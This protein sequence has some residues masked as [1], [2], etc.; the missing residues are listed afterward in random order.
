MIQ[1]SINLKYKPSSEPPAMIVIEPNPHKFTVL[2]VSGW[3]RSSR[4]PDL[5]GLNGMQERRDV[6]VW[7][8]GT[9]AGRQGQRDNKRGEG[10][11]ERKR[12][13]KEEK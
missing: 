11:K 8:E 10:E 3:F 4:C 9:G 2:G 1:K 12:A 7:Y 13:G 5:T 6:R